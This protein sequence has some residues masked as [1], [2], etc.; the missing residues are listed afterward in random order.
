MSFISMR[1]KLASS[2]REREVLFGFQF[3]AEKNNT[4]GYLNADVGYD[5]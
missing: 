5:K 4:P 1:A 2:G 3:C